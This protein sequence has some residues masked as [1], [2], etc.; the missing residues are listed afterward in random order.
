MHSVTSEL[1]TVAVKAKE[2]SASGQPIPRAWWAA[3]CVGQIFPIMVPMRSPSVVAT[4]QWERSPS[5]TESSYP[6]ARKLPSRPSARCGSIP[7]KSASAA[8]VAAVTG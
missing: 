7:P 8:A 6:T 3:R 2:N 5:A 4:D 1:A